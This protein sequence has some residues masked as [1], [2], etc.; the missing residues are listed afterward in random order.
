MLHV[1]SLVFAC[2]IITVRAL[3]VKV[4]YASYG[5][6][7][8]GVADL[9]AARAISVFQGVVLVMA[10]PMTNL[11]ADELSL[12]HDD[13]PTPE[14]L[15][16]LT[17]EAFSGRFM[18]ADL[19]DIHDMGGFVAKVSEDQTLVVPPGFLIAEFHMQPSIM[20]ITPCLSSSH[21]RMIPPGVF[22]TVPILVVV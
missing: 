8:L 6:K 17:V 14:Q 18:K 15:E 19:N 16:S 21:C 10:A 7:W 1:V 5:Y 22:D 12:D 4:H 3:N 13:N 20:T 2:A 11:I 9:L